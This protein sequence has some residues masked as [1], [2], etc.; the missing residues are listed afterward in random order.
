MLDNESSS[1]KPRS[2]K[3]LGTTDSVA[4]FFL[5]LNPEHDRHI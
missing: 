3:Q 2:N 1:S 5:S 4:V